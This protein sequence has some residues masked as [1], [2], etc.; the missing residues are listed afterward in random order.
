[1]GA[2]AM[3][4]QTTLGTRTMVSAQF[5]GE[6]GEIAFVTIAVQ[7][8]VAGRQAAIAQLFPVSGNLLHHAVE[9]LLKGVL[10]RTKSLEELRA[11]R[12]NLK[13]SWNA[14]RA[15]FPED[16]LAEFTPAVRTLNKFERLR[17]PDELLTT[18]MVGMFALFRE[19]STS[20]S[21]S[22]STGLPLFSLVL[23]DVDAFVSRT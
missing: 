11:N 7:Y 12:H 20:A 1:M 16:E 23:E 14:F 2:N 17:Y 8:Y 9:M 18:G 13:R 19:H 15:S 3:F 22:A 10:C 21:G 5:V 4:A 6:R